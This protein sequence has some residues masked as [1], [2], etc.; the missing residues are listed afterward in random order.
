MANHRST[1]A[2]LAFVL[3]GGGAA[4]AQDE[5]AAAF[6][7]AYYLESG[8]RDFQQAEK[9]Y[10]DLAA[11]ATAPAAKNYLVSALIG[12]GR[13]LQTL[14]RH[15][16]AKRVLESALAVDPDNA[17]ATRLLTPSFEDG[18]DPELKVR[19]T[20]LVQKL[21]TAERDQAM[22]DLGKVGAL[23]LPFLRDGLRS[24]D[25]AIVENCA[26]VLTQQKS[27]AAYRVLADGFR[28]PAVL[29][30]QRLTSNF[31]DLAAIPETLD[32]LEAAMD[33]SDVSIR[34]SAVNQTRNLSGDRSTLDR[35][36]L[37]E[38]L[39]RALRD[40]DPSVAQRLA[41]FG[42]VADEIV[43]ELSPDLVPWLKTLSGYALESALKSIREMTGTVE[44]LEEFAAEQLEHEDGGVR[45][46]AVQWL[47]HRLEHD[48]VDP[49]LAFE[50]LLART[51]DPASDIVRDAAQTLEKY[52][53]LWLDDESAARVRSLV[54]ESSRGPSSKAALEIVSRLLPLLARQQRVDEAQLA[55]HFDAIADGFPRRSGEENY[56]FVNAIYQAARFATDDQ[57]G[58]IQFFR[59]CFRRHSEEVVQIAILDL[60]SRL[61][62]PG[63]DPPMK[64][65]ALESPHV[66][67]RGRLYAQIANTS[68][69]ARQT[70]IELSPIAYSNLGDDINSPNPVVANPAW[71]LA[72]LL[73]SPALADAVKQRFEYS[74]SPNRADI[75]FLYQSCGGFDSVPILEQVLAAPRSR[76]EWQSA[77]FGLM[78]YQGVAALPNVVATI[79]D[80]PARADDLAGALQWGPGSTPEGT[81]L[82][83]EGL[84]G[85]LAP[86]QISFELLEQANE[87]LE[88]PVPII[89]EKGLQATD[90]RARA[91]ACRIAGHWRQESAEPKLLELLDRDVPSVSTAAQV[92]LDN[93]RQ[94]RDLRSATKYSLGFDKSKAIAEARALLGDQDP[95]KRRGGALALGALG[96]VSAVPL[97]LRLLDDRDVQVRETALTALGKLNSAPTPS[98]TSEPSK[99][100]G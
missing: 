64:S 77:A 47:K 9:A 94:R 20:A 26:V 39:R 24:R 76:D 41:D 4:R 58:L 60:V 45:V 81:R 70:S 91:L 89:V 19:I 98:T 46:R 15:D 28:D 100:D 82:L 54:L 87:T 35:G 32:V 84:A 11:K 62:S 16:E 92:A 5:T 34:T 25:V 53:Q 71:D 27:P 17:E 6:Y 95:L 75:L 49:K 44:E 66:S 1:A 96:D 33:S 23:A 7:K 88:A 51:R 50:V 29:F 79:G 78:K 63:S 67:I 48:A 43:I 21:G 55:E 61:G 12:R 65:V 73:P 68:P 72:K 97:L 59:N 38:L 8:L 74:D 57:A 99:S 93:I 31:S 42:F 13:C 90:P 56:A 69:A 86:H 22:N 36:R 80:D 83:F 3:L 2:L 30:P 40:P 10:A 85:Q 52:P 18:I 14:G 37:V